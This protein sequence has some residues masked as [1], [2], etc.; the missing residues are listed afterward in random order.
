MS[1]QSSCCS[2]WVSVITLHINGKK[3][4][5][6]VKGQVSTEYLPWIVLFLPNLTECL[7]SWAGCCWGFFSLYLFSLSLSPSELR[8][9]SSWAGL[10][11]AGG[12][13]P[14]RTT[15][16]EQ[17]RQEFYERADLLFITSL[18]HSFSHTP[19]FSVGW[20]C[21][22]P[23]SFLGLFLFFL[24]FMFTHSFSAD[25]LQESLVASLGFFPQS[26]CVKWLLV[27]RYGK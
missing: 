27:C 26:V 19:L 14:I 4:R 5:R 12:K 6:G 20:L 7:V 15:L 13:L 2:S 8:P 24:Y 17:C 18:S 1:V 21:H 25:F 23:T 22:T 10:Y 3:K 9:G 16:I 11:C